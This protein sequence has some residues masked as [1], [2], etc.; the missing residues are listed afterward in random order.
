MAGLLRKN[1]IGILDRARRSF[2]PRAVR[3]EAPLEELLWQVTNCSENSHLCKLCTVASAA[4]EDR[5]TCFAIEFEEQPES[6]KGWSICSNNR[7]TQR[8]LVSEMLT[9]RAVVASH[10]V[11]LGDMSCWVF[12]SSLYA[13]NSEPA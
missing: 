12:Q 2:A 10:P 3:G 8:L 11:D 1:G 9:L 13:V 7:N 5:W 4:F 6:I